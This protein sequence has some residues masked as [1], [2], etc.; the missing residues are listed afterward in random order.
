MLGAVLFIEVW[1]LTLIS[2]LA[3]WLYYKLIIIAE[4]EFLRRKFG[5]LYLEWLGKTPAFLPRFRNW[6][7][8]ELPF[9]FKAVAAREYTTLFVIIASFSLMDITGDIFVEGKL[10]LAWAAVFIADFILYSTLRI[11]KKK[12][13]ILYVEGR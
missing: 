8:P 7:K 5:D 12:T 6:Q 3:F 2:V 4:E 9:S 10:D 11:L 1:W 13:K